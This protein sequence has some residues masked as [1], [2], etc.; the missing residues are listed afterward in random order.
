MWRI[1]IFLLLLWACGSPLYDDFVKA[2]APCTFYYS[3]DVPTTA[4]PAC[5]YDPGNTNPFVPYV[6]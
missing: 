1:N 4:Q 3:W 2:G 5:G 6:P